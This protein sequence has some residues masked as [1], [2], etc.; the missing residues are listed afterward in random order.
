[1]KQKMIALIL[2]LALLTI[3]VFSYAALA[4]SCHHDYSKISYSSKSVFNHSSS[5]YVEKNGRKDWWPVIYY[6]DYTIVEYSCAQCGK[7]IPELTVWR[8]S[9]THWEFAY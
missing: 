8:L 2:C 4:D 5:L 7:A 1:M 6:D 9:G 3:G